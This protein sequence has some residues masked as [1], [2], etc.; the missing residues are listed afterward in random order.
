MRLRTR[1]FLSLAAAAVLGLL[2]AALNGGGSLLIGWAGATFLSFLA[3]LS[4]LTAWHWAG[5]R[6]ALA[7]MVALAFGLRLL[8]GIGISYAL[9]AYGYQDDKVQHSGYIYA[10]AFTRDNDAWDLAQSGKPILSS[11]ESQIVSDQ[12]GGA[13]ALSA[14]VYRYLS[15]DTHRRFLILILTAFIAALGVPFFW[16]AVKERWGEPAA[17]TAAWVLALYPESLL[18][19]GSQLREPFLIG[20]G[21]IG[22]W[23]VFAWRRNRWGALAAAAISML[24]MGLFSW[25]AAAV[26]LGILAVVFFLDHVDDIPRPALRAAV[27]VGLGLAVAGVAYF[28]W[29]WLN[30]A[31]SYDAGLAIRNSGWVQKIVRQL[32][33]SWRMPFVTAYGLA[34][35]VLPA[36]LV[37]PAPWIWKVIGFFRSLG[38]YALVPV[39]V[40]AFFAAWKGVGRRERKL[41]IGIGLACLVWVIISSARAG[42]DQWDNPRYRAILL[43]W[44]AL[45]AGWGWQYAR[46]TK[47][48][49]LWRWSAAEVIF[50]AF[51]LWWYVSRYTGL[52]GRLDFWVMVAVI[53]GLGVL[54]M[55]VP[56]L[57]GRIRQPRRTG[58]K[59]NLLAEVRPYLK[60]KPKEDLGQL[61][62][63]LTGNSV[64][65]GK[66]HVSRFTFHVFTRQ[67]NA[68][69]V[70]V[71]LAFLAFA[72]IY[73]LG[74]LQANYPVV[75]L[76]GDGGNIASYAAAQDHP[77]WF[78]LDPALG[79]PTNTGV[80]ATIHIPLIRAIERL[81]GDYGQA[82]AWLL[83]PQTFLQLLG[84]YILG[85]MLFKN[86][87]WAFLFAFLTAMMVIDVGLGEIWG[88]WRDALPRVTFQALL[89]FLLAL[90]LAW[91]DRP[92]RWPWLMLLAGLLVYVHPVSAPAWGFAIWLGLWLFVPKAWR[93]RQ[94][95][96]VMLGL[97][98]AFLVPIL[99]FAVNYLSYQ[100]RGGAADYSTVMAILQAYSPANLLNI[101]AA[102]G[103]FLWNMTRSLLIPVALVG[104][105]A[106]W[107]LK[108]DDRKEVKLVLL[109]T[110]GI[111][112]TSILIPFGEQI[113]EALLKM[114]PFETEL[115]RG[116]RYFV[117]LLLI[118]W[119]WPLVELA[120]RLVHPRARQAAFGLG[121]L[122]FAF[123]GGTNRPDVRYMWKAVT[124]LSQG[125]L[126]C[127][128]DRPLDELIVT[129][130]TQTQPGD[131]IFFFNQSSATTSQT[132]SVRYSA[133]RPLV[134]SP[135]DQST[136]GYANRAALPAWLA[137]NRQ[138]E[139]LQA[140]E[141]P[142]AR[143][144][145]LLPL[146]QSLKASYLVIDF[147]VT[148][149]LLKNLPL[150]VVMENEVYT[151][152]DVRS[153]RSP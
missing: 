8:L 2:I 49:A 38:W 35:P 19:G 44:L 21:C 118:F 95:I 27:W 66:N 70:L 105:A 31:S 68:L 15:P 153:P 117:P 52:V 75:V 56:W 101:P 102:L 135:R 60:L 37:D 108:K 1:I 100:S 48:A 109:W 112:V 87:F 130:R 110:A 26:V 5:G 89:P 149:Q 46:R 57:W 28:S 141:D 116:I 119:L 78:T 40:Y 144:A 3:I 125:Q 23:A 128:S 20:L 14:A 9:I 79:D 151:L 32:G 142:Q 51:F 99:P 72:A 55:L 84:F 111:F 150:K 41:F 65:A 139:A 133:L 106:T 124:C 22:F 81:T 131:G 54:V 114:L 47:D 42:G 10:D 126:V 80:Y 140:Q 17:N 113:I 147:P 129:L 43:P 91:K 50:V 16:R 61:G 7:W 39:L 134:F 29:G 136:L 4:L 59:F 74:R 103:E 127:E 36:I 152:L 34:Q 82:F 132:L 63:G 90:V 67:I 53:A 33:E 85:R 77:A 45:L 96:L 30:T 94:R 64:L 86:R 98:A 62:N 104:F 121:I 148:E 122:L 93:V 73:F 145:G 24:L 69:D 6:R 11:F 143:L 12:Y 146:A 137:L 123:W 71:I 58:Q 18:L 88:V 97:G 13:L 76:T 138:V 107:I 83:L 115:V 92:A 25:R 120:P